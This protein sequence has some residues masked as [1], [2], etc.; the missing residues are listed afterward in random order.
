MTRKIKIVVVL[1]I[2]AMVL[3]GCSLLQGSQ[4]HTVDISCTCP[5][6]AGGPLKAVIP[7]ILSV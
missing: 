3:T 5:P 6:P 2:I 4:R 1:V 7:E